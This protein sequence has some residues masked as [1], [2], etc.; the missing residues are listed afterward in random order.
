MI[1]REFRF[2]VLGDREIEGVISNADRGRDGFRIIT[3]GIDT[4]QYMASSPVLLWSHDP[5]EPIGHCTHLRV[6]GDSLIGHFQFAAEAVSATADRVYALVRGQTLNCFSIGFEPVKI[7]PPDKEGVRT[8]EKSTLLEVSIV[9]VP[10]LPAARITARAWRSTMSPEAAANVVRASEA[11]DAAAAHCQTVG[12]CLKR[13]LDDD[14]AAAHQRCGRCINTAQR[15]FR[16]VGDDATP[17][18]RRASREMGDA[19]IYHKELGDALG[20]DDEETAAAHGRLDRSIGRARRHLRDA[21]D[22]AALADIANNQKTQNSGGMGKG[23]S[24]SGRALS[25]YQRQLALRALTPRLPVGDGGSR[26]RCCDPR[27]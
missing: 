27:L 9:S 6:A 23:T 10:A 1:R 11:V 25:F 20:Y 8:I 21:A 4:S 15:C 3:R 22:E 16:A 12:Q 2:A 5:S 14:A 17:A 13:G 24:D 26:W 7:G 19:A 18:I